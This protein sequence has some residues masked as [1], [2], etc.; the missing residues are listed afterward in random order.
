MWLALSATAWFA[1]AAAAAPLPAGESQGPI[2]DYLR[3]RGKLP[4]T[5]PPHVMQVVL[6]DGDM[7][8]VGRR[9]VQYVTEARETKVVKDGKEVVVTTYVTVPVFRESKELVAAKDCKFFTLAKDGKLEAVE[10][11]KATALLKKPTA[12]LAGE[13]A[14]VDPRHLELVKPGTLYLV[15]PPPQALK[16]APPAIDKTPAA[17]LDK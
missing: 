16:I 7:I 12:V 5:A 17:P 4:A 9:M 1:A 10:A 11:K 15:V 6:G 14:E 3:L 13:S 2:S 8:E